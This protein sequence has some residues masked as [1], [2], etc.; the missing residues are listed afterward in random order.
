MNRF[1][2]SSRKRINVVIYS[3][4][5]IWGLV[6][7]RLFY[8]QIIQHNS[9]ENI[10]N[11]QTK[12]SKKSTGDRGIISDRNHIPLTQNINRYTFWVNTVDNDMDIPGIA[13]MFSEVFEK[14]VDVYF[15]KIR[16]ISSYNVLE[17]DIK[18][19]DCT[20]ILQ[21]KKLKGLNI[22]KTVRRY[23]PYSN[24]AAQ[25][26]GYTDLNNFGVIGIE[27]RFNQILTGKTKP[28]VLNHK[29]MPSLQIDNELPESGSDIILTIDIEMQTILQDELNRRLR[30]TDAISANGV[31]LDPYSGEIL[32][33]ATVPSLD[34][35]RYQNF[36]V[37]HQVNKVI[38]DVYE[39][40]STF[41]IIAMAGKLES[42]LVDSPAIYDCENGS[43]TF[44]NKIF[45]DHEKHNELSLAEILMYSSNIGMI[46]I[47]NEIGDKNVFHYTRQFG[48]GSPTGVSL[49]GES[50]GIVNSLS[51]WSGISGPEIAIGQE[52]AVNNLQLAMAYCAVANGGYLLKPQIIK[53]INCSDWYRYQ[54]QPQLVRKCIL[55]ET[56]EKLLSMLNDVVTQGTGAEAGIPGFHIAGKTGTAQKVVDGKYSDENFIS[57]F[58]A[59]FPA[60]NPRYV[61]IVSVDSP[62]YTRGY[63]WG[64]QT[65]APIVK[66]IF[67]RIIFREDKKKSDPGS[68]FIF[69]N[70]ANGK[71][72]SNPEVVGKSNILWN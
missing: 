26:I 21:G 71:K 27:S 10:V 48:F 50:N 40:G 4:I 42:G 64:S 12:I 14:P 37:S 1:Y 47:A 65:A 49:P 58:A 46:K 3:I 5:C 60:E 23:Y 69:A 19:A 45:K 38:S 29:G 30:M 13:L 66:R 33:M 31:I 51:R 17:K 56:S 41:K 2:K 25:L 63:H 52:I 44:Y 7:V 53:E 28:V 6:F 32:A 39:P 36:P 54:N 11:K 34:L 67:E 20:Q 18:E 70:T 16:Q 62:D 9:F 59:I 24:L 22:E 72:D 43:F 68:H 55:S 35:N 8:I 15:Q 61:C 57:S